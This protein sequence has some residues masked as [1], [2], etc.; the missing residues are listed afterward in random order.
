MLRCVHS[1]L[2][3]LSQNVSPERVNHILRAEQAAAD[4]A[5]VHNLDKQQAAT[6]NLIHPTAKC[7][8]PQRL[9]RIAQEEGLILDKILSANPHLSHADVGSI[10][11]SDTFGVKDEQV[12]SRIANH[13]LAAADSIELRRG[14]S[15]SLQALRQISQENIDL[16]VY[17]TRDYT[18]NKLLNSPHSIHPR[19]ITTRNKLLVKCK[20]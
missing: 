16:A 2:T 4:L 18:L 8:K 17:L 5:V 12:L 10:V 9:L 7:F 20:Y 15:A 3:Y 13:T 11:A 19:L 6:A 1:V 14:D